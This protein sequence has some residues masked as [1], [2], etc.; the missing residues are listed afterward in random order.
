MDA[1][2]SC[3]QTPRADASPASFS[4]RV[5]A[6]FKQAMIS[7]PS[8]LWRGDDD[9]HMVRQD[10][11]G[12][13]RQIDLAANRGDTLADGLGLEAGELYRRILER[14]LRRKSQPHVMRPTGH[15]MGRMD[16]CRFTAGFVDVL[17][18]ARALS[19]C[20]GDRSAARSRRC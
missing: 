5:P 1:C 11:T 4:A 16:L 6:R 9:M 17:R 19:R 7:S 13:D 15:G 14:F 18:R 8:S 12:V 20:R 3:A 2:H 10:R